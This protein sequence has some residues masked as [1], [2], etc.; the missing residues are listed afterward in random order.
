MR[1]QAAVLYGTGEPLRIEDLRLEGP[2]S[3]EVLVRLAAS[4]VCHSDYHTVTGQVPLPLPMVLGHEGAG[5]VEA[6][7]PNVSSVRPGDHVILSWMAAC[8]RCRQCLEGHSN[9]CATAMAGDDSLMMD[10]TTRLSGSGG[11]I[12]HKARLATFADHTVVPVDAVIKIR[13][14]A[15]LDLA[16]LVGCAVMT[17]VGAAIRAAKVTV[18]SRC[19][20]IGCGGVGLNVI[21]GCA[22]AGAAQIVAIDTRSTKSDLARSFGATDFVDASTEE[23]VQAVRS[24]TGGGCDYAFEVVGSPRTTEQALEMTRQGGTAVVVGVPAQNARASVDIN[25]LADERILKGTVYGSANL[26]VDIPMMVDLYMAG[27]LKLSELVTARRPLR[28]INEAFRDLVEGDG[29]RTVIEF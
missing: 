27:R 8:G 1:V 11:P 2:R 13:D 9:I 20:V 29:A 24:L 16:A 18:G 12:H 10:G 22:L 3:D 5:V 4:G 25:F 23:P 6:I 15:P 21:Q 19:A 26:R 17:G 28:E 14:D 7:G